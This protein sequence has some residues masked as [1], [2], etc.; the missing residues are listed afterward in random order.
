MKEG[1]RVPK[2]ASG[3]WV[4]S[5]GL[6]EVEVYSCAR[7]KGRVIAW[8]SLRSTLLAGG[9]ASSLRLNKRPARSV[10]PSC[11]CLTFTSLT[12]KARACFS[13]AA[14]ARTHASR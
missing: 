13:S 2:R 9:E 10:G 12:K 14:P 8:K 11:Q 4:L 6:R 3:R 7:E 5:Y 1:P